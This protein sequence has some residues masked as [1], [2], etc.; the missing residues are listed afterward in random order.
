MEEII[1]NIKC[2]DRCL[3]QERKRNEGKRLWGRTFEKSLLGREEKPYT[4]KY[5]FFQ[6]SVKGKQNNY[7]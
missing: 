7:N 1:E 4:G 3:E 6:I 5:I 2:T